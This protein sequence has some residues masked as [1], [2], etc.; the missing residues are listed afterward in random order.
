VN[1]NRFDW[2]ED[3]EPATFFVD[4]LA[5]VVMFVIGVAVCWA[6]K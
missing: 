1:D 6:C 4:V 3:D 2:R 5:F